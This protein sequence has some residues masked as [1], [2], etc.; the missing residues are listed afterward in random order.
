MKNKDNIKYFNHPGEA[1]NW[2]WRIENGVSDWINRQGRKGNGDKSYWRLVFWVSQTHLGILKDKMSLREFAQL[3]IEECPKALHKDE[4]Q[5]KLF[6]S[7]EK[8]PYTGNLNDFERQ[9]DSSFVRTMVGEVEELLTK[10]V[11]MPME[12]VPTLEQRMLEFA[13]NALVT[14]CY[15]K[16]CVNPT[17]NGKRVSLSVEKYI[18]QKFKDENRPTFVM[19]FEC[20]EDVVTEETIYSLYGKFSTFSSKPTNKLYVVSTN[21]FTKRTQDEAESHNMG[22]V[23]V[24][25]EYE[26]DEHCFI[27]PRSSVRKNYTYWRQMLSGEQSMTLPFIACDGPFLFYSLSEILKSNNFSVNDYPEIKAPYLSNIEIE[28]E[29]MDLVKPQVDDLVSMLQQCGSSDCIPE[30]IINPYPLAQSMGL[31]VVSGYT[32][33]N[34]S[35][36]DIENKTVTISGN[37]G[38]NY[39]C[40]RFGLSH[41]LGHFVFHKEMIVNAKSSNQEIKPQEMC[42]MEHH[43]NYFASCL[44]MPA[45]IVHI[46]Y[47][48]YYKRETN[49]SMVMPLLVNDDNYPD[50]ARRIIKKLADNMCVS[51]E[52]MAIRLEKM[53]L[54]SKESP[55]PP[56]LPEAF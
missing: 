26:V 23:L 25:L 13:N 46:L 8:F 51:V 36:I 52:A 55:M 16:V 47:N 14:G 1:D 45:P 18:S 37:L 15:D 29:A 48:H 2:V 11:E 9:P 43:A 54:I 21:Y 42:W 17:Y 22:L 28:E 32:G 5:D 49:G 19:A 56:Y 30:C 20:V 24:N 35:N 44:L 10:A 3:L 7:M 4:T 33:N 34:I 31:R 41:E 53:G 27:L 50:F 38:F 40:T 12:M 6:H 39:H